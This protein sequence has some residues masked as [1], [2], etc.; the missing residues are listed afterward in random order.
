MREMKDSGVAWIDNIPKDWAIIPLKM[1]AEYR[2]G[3]S[4][5]KADLS[6]TGIPVV[7]YGQIHSKL[8]SGTHL[9]D[10][11]IRFV[12]PSYLSSNPSSIGKY[13]DLLFADTSE[14]YEGIGNAVYL[15]TSEC[16]FA[17]Y[18]TI[19]VRPTIDM[20]RKYLA[21]L[22]RSDCWRSQLRARAFG[23]KV[24]SVTQTMLKSVSILLPPTSEQQKIVSIKL[25]WSML[26]SRKLSAEQLS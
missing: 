19:I 16:V 5:T 18:H 21:Y 7:S 6:E 20:E 15:D 4:I 23:I 11:L 17:G 8:N 14:D 2:K 26:L 24:Y 10:N 3:L 9:S 1:V 12:S 25:S 13:G 22:C